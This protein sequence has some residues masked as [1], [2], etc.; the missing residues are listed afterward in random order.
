MIMTRFWYCFQFFHVTPLLY[1]QSPIFQVFWVIFF[2]NKSKASIP[3]RGS[4]QSGFRLYDGLRPACR[5]IWSPVWTTNDAG[6]GWLPESWIAFLSPEKIKAYGRLSVRGFDVVPVTSKQP[7]FHLTGE[8]IFS[9]NCRRARLRGESGVD[10][11]FP[12]PMPHVRKSGATC[13]EGDICGNSGLQAGEVRHGNPVWR[14][15]LPRGGG[16][17]SHRTGECPAFPMYFPVTYSRPPIVSTAFYIVYGSTI[18]HLINSL[19]HLFLNFS[20]LH[21]LDSWG[22]FWLSIDFTRHRNKTLH[23]RWRFLCFSQKISHFPMPSVLLSFIFL[24]FWKDYL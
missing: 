23:C 1:I 5:H 8:A 2:Q 22:L 6:C 21:L 11:G 4:A 15:A 16:H 9:F 12:A 13:L 20:H 17:Q 19:N 7:P 10:K 18:L 3:W 14:T 24:F